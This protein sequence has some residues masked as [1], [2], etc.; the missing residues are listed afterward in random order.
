MPSCNITVRIA[1]VTAPASL[2]IAAVQTHLLDIADDGTLRHLSNGL[3]VANRQSC[4][5]ASVDS[6][7]S[8][9]RSRISSVCLIHKT[10]SIEWQIKDSPLPDM[11]GYL[12]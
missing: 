9:A 1:Y 10:C 12:L 4:L 8:S 3:D 11:Q 7:H 6:L 2:N 5:L